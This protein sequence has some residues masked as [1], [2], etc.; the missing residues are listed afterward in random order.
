[1]AEGTAT[2]LGIGPG[3][4]NFSVMISVLGLSSDIDKVTGGLKLL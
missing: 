1:M 4:H 3:L 2:V